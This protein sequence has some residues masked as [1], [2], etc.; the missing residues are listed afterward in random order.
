MQNYYYRPNDYHRHTQC[1]RP[2]PAAPVRPEPACPPCTNVKPSESCS[3]DTLHNHTLAMAYVPWQEWHDLYPLEK[4][5]CKGTIF[6]ELD[7]PFSGTGGC[8]K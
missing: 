4:S 2:I 6:E 8:C 3:T 1:N 7:K 5:L